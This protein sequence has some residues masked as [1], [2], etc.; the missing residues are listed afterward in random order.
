M[1]V[2]TSA[3]ACIRPAQLLANPLRFGFIEFVRHIK[4]KSETPTLIFGNWRE[5]GKRK[6]LTLIVEEEDLFILSGLQRLRLRCYAR[7]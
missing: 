1:T 4:R 7:D 5:I 3:L 6:G 2:W